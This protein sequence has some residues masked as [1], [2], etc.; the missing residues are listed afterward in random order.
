MEESLFKNQG[1]ITNFDEVLGMLS[2]YISKKEDIDF[3]TRAFNY[4]NEKHAGQVRK[5]GEPYINHCL[6]VAYILATYQSA[7]ATIA[8]GFL[9][10]TLE[11]CG[12]SYQEIRTLFNDDVAEIVQAVTKIKNL[13]NV[14]LEETS[15]STHRK[16][17]LAMAKDIRAVIVKLCDRLH[18][19]RTLQYVKPHKQIETSKETLEV[20]APLA[21]RLG[22]SSLK[23]ELENL[24]LYYLKSKE[25]DIVDSLVNERLA[26]HQFDIDEIIKNISLLL[27]D[28]K[29]PHRIFGRT[30]HTYSIYKKMYVKHT[31][32][33][34]IFDL[35][36]IRIITQTKLQCYEILG[37]IHT[38]Y[39]PIPGRFKDYIAMPKTNMYQSLHTTVLD[40]N[41]ELFEIQIRTEEM[42]YVAE[43]GIA[44]HWIYK[45]SAGEN[46]SKSQEL[47]EQQL[48]WLRD[49]IKINEDSA[50]TSDVEYMKQVQKD[51][52]ET[53]IYVL[54]PKGKIIDMPN[55]STP[56]D[57]AYRVHT[58]VGNNCVGA[59]VNKVIVP[60]ST[61]LQNGD[62]V[63][64]K[65]AKNNYGPSEDWLSFVK[66]NTARSQ[67]KKALLKRQQTT[68]DAIKHA[69]TMYQKGLKIFEDNCKDRFVDFEESVALL[70]S[71][72]ILNNF[73]VS[74]KKDLFILIGQKSI[75]STSVLAKIY[76]QN[77]TVE[78]QIDSL[79]RKG[80]S[81][82][83]SKAKGDIIVDGNSS[84]IKIEPAVCCK[85]I[86]GDEIM[87]FITRGSGIKVHRTDCHNILNEKRRLISARWNEIDK[88]NVYPV[89][90]EIL[91]YDRNNLLVDLMGLISTINIRIDS[92]SARS[93]YE[94]K[95]ATLSCTVYVNNIDS[96]NILISKIKSIHGIISI[97]RVCR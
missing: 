14:S 28:N 33:E 63:E 50:D 78:E 43:R 73:D 80:Y 37:I 92:L 51:L 46:I 96:L 44:A 8:A 58:Q 22:M 25:F 56:V 2:T 84:G 48:S 26:K 52:F 87:G 19:M 93:H 69:E 15:A 29:I 79:K 91:S 12:V 89:D 40:D 60:L 36:A 47:S 39:K 88:N 97:T 76:D 24:C 81:V 53:S 3:I 57:F 13:P 7:P 55:G 65:T 17:I 82:K 11:D 66:T 64:I 59:L 61:E 38:I 95:T 49:L 83:R 32:F 20:Y 42:D 62:I 27:Q 23:N 9:H 6:S 31:P 10:D 21:H 67:I 86:P 94:N 1:S 71:L 41:G 16:L 74:N 4:A 68:D 85:P 75:S 90:L 54:T 45:E 35:Q 30:K 77:R 18:N 5:S 34:K 72:T 70:D